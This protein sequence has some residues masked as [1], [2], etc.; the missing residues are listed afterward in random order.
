MGYWPTLIFDTSGINR[1]ADDSDYVALIAGLQSGF[2]VRITSTSICEIIAS[3]DS[4]RR[5]KLLNVCKRL[6]ASGHCLEP[7]SVILTKLMQ[8][9][10]VSPPP[11][12]WLTIS[13]RNP[14]AEAEIA[15]QRII[16]DA[17]SE[18]ERGEA[19]VNNKVFV[20]VY[21]DAKLNLPFDLSATATEKIPASVSELV[22]VLQNEG[23]FW[24]VSSKWYSR[25]LKKS[26]SD[27]MI[28]EFVAKC[29]PF[30]ALM[31]A[32]CAVQYDRCVRPSNVGPS[33]KTGRNDTFMSIYLP[34]CNQFV[35]DDPRQLKCFQ[36]VTS[37]SGLDTAVRSYE[38]FRSGF[39]VMRTAAN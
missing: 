20:E 27:A 32:L 36:E 9:F 26:P 21:N 35:T 6:L 13:V 34:Y 5:Q 29:P 15:R 10:D 12:N 16:N 8:G 3:E 7:P 39:F 30:R 17:L 1:L 2:D 18:N 24:R 23:A 11:F 25:T 38:E 19:R 22:T 14:D 4:D 31:T 33:L 37:V 28:R